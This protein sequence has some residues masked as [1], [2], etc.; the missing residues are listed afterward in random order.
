MFSSPDPEPGP[1]GPEP[2][3]AD[4]NP[5]GPEYRAFALFAQLTRTKRDLKRQLDDVE[6]KLDS[7]AF[8]LRDYLGSGG[9]DRVHVDGFTIYLRRELWA[10]KYEWVPTDQV[11]AALKRNGLAQ[12]VKETYNS[13]TLSQHIRQLEMTHK[14]ELTT[15]KVEGVADLLAPD[16]ARLLNLEPTYNVIA[17]ET[18]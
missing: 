11:C 14:D 4:W 17:L 18:E 2:E 16:L 15:G 9:F 1:L 3:N 8:Q 6:R 12:F 10:R 7:L 13:N 5:R